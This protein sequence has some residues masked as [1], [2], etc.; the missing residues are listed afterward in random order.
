MDKCEEGMPFLFS[1]RVLRSS[2]HLFCVFVCEYALFFLACA[3][4]SVPCPASSTNITFCFSQ[5]NQI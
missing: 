5:R 4:N 1:L 2:F 3:G